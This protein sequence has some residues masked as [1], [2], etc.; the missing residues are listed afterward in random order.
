ML[1]RIRGNTK[2][3]KRILGC[4]GIGSVLVVLANI[5]VMQRIYESYTLW[6][7]DQTSLIERFAHF[8]KAHNSN[9]IPR[10]GAVSP[11]IRA[12]TKPK[13]PERYEMPSGSYTLPELFERW[14]TVG[15]MTLRDDKVF[16]ERY[17]KGHSASRLWMSFSASKAIVGVLTGIAAEEGA[18]EDLS[19]PLGKYAPQF[20]G[21]AWEDVTFYQAL[22]MRSGVDFYEYDYDWG[23]DLQDFTF[24]MAIG[25]PLDDWLVSLPKSEH[26]PGSHYIYSSADTQALGTALSGAT[27]KTI[28]Q[29]MSEKIWTKI[30]VEKDAYWIADETGREVGLSGWNAT[31]RDYARLGLLYLHGSNWQGEEIIPQ[32]WLERVRN[33]TAEHLAQE[34]DPAAEKHVRSWSQFY[35]PD[36]GYGDYSAVGAYGQ[37]IYVNPRMNAVVVTH[38]V[39][40]DVYNEMTTLEEQFFVFRQIAESLPGETVSVEQVAEPAD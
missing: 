38:S 16:D 30:G 1:K 7:A 19:D 17:F 18:I 27:G 6:T 29:Y 2:M 20:R 14:G 40:P 10:A 4:L 21:S 3:L 9:D 35:V 28:A 39:N 26:P 12:E 32:H 24:A 25:T 15:F 34:P 37:L 5:T 23:G 33:P 36:D 11:L 22:D 8:N 31:M 13:Y